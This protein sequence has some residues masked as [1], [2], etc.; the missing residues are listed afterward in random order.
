MAAAQR[1]AQQVQRQPDPESGHF[2]ADHAIAPLA[3]KT[4]QIKVQPGGLLG[5]KAVEK[6]GGIDVIRRRARRTL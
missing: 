6:T 4:A 2:T 5:H 1:A 3:A